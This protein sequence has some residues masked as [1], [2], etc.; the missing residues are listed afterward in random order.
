MTSRLIGATTNAF[1]PNEA[2][3]LIDEPGSGLAGDGPALIQTLCTTPLTGCAAT[4]G[5]LPSVAGGNIVAAIGA[6]GTYA[7]NV[8]QGTSSSTT[9]TP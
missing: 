8:Y 2:L 4:V 7:P 1:L 3:L 6:D 5:S 9:A